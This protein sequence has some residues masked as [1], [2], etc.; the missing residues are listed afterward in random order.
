MSWTKDARFLFE[1]G[2]RSID[3]D[4]FMEGE[5]QGILVENQPF[6]QSPD[7]FICVPFVLSSSNV[8]YRCHTYAVGDYISSLEKAPDDIALRVVKQFFGTI[9]KKR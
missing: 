1:N 2:N 7:Q 9:K 6:S 3:C 4:V 8:L 5:N